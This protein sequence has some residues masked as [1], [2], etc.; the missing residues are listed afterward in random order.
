M[1]DFSGNP[2]LL[3]HLLSIHREGLLKKKGM[4]ETFQL[5]VP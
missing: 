2:S 3:E 5:L 4:E 1:L